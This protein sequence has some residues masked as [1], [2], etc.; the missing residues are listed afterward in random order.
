MAWSL[1][2]SFPELPDNP[3]SSGKC[4]FT[5]IMRDLQTRLWFVFTGNQVRSAQTTNDIARLFDDHPKSWFYALIKLMLSSFWTARR[6]S[7]EQGL[8]DLA[9]QGKLDMGTA[10]RPLTGEFIA[11]NMT[12]NYDTYVL[13][14]MVEQAHAHRKLHSPTLWQHDDWLL[15]FQ[16]WFGTAAKDTLHLLEA[17]HTLCQQQQVTPNYST[18]VRKVIHNLAHLHL[19]I[20]SYISQRLKWNSNTLLWL[21]AFH[22]SSTAD[23]KLIEHLQIMYQLRPFDP[24]SF[25]LN[26]AWELEIHPDVYADLKHS[27]PAFEG[28]A[29]IDYSGCPAMHATYTDAQGKVHHNIILDRIRMLSS[30]YALQKK[31]K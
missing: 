5:K 15:S 11:H 23:A 10:I 13:Q 14:R 8:H 18:G 7:I 22:P 19:R 21:A 31:Q 30:A 25:V 16:S 27:L 12:P 1:P 26:A 17:Y 28:K 4:P 20:F 29:D 3:E 2:P 9:A 24:K 6:R